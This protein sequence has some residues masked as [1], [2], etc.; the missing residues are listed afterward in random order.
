MADRELPSIDRIRQWFR[1]DQRTG[2]VYFRKQTFSAFAAAL[3]EDGKEPKNPRQAYNVQQ[4]RAGRQ[5]GSLSKRGYIQLSINGR[6]F[7]AHR[8]VWCLV[9]GEWPEVIDHIDGNRANNRL[10]NLRSVTHSDNLKNKGLSR[11]NKSGA[12]GVTFRHGKWSARFRSNGKDVHCGTFVKMQDAIDAL[13][14]ARSRHGFT[15]NHGE[16]R[17]QAYPH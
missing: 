2:N 6:T 17:G 10:R 8:A 14:E 13:R 15:E 16:D 12:T 4:A 5:A 11:A 1:Y 3:K 7:G 9:H